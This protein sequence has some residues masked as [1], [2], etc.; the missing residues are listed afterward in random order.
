MVCLGLKAWMVKW[1][2]QPNP[3]SYG[4]RNVIATLLAQWTL[5]D[6]IV[7]GVPGTQSWVGKMEGADKSTELWW[8]PTKGP[9][10][11]GDMRSFKILFH[12]FKFLFSMTEVFLLGRYVGTQHTHTHVLLSV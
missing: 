11:V 4:G 3:L 9:I 6:K 12:H 8:H 2:V 5:N 10:F 1:K 7:Y